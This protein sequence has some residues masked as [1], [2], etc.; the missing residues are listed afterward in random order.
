M[1]TLFRNMLKIQEEWI[2]RPSGKITSQILFARLVLVLI[3]SLLLQKTIYAGLYEDNC[4]ALSGVGQMTTACGDGFASLTYAALELVGWEDSDIENLEAKEEEFEARLKSEKTRFLAN[5]YRELLQYYWQYQNVRSET[6]S[7][8]NG[9]VTGESLFS[10]Y[11]YDRR[12]QLRDKQKQKE[13]LERRKALARELIRFQRAIN[14]I[15]KAEEPLSKRTQEISSNRARLAQGVGTSRT[16]DGSVM[17]LNREEARIIEELNRLKAA[18]FTILNNYPILDLDIWKKRVGNQI[19]SMPSD[20]EITD[21]D[22]NYVISNMLDPA[23]LEIQDNIMKEAKATCEQG[24]G[25]LVGNDFLAADAVYESAIFKEIYCREYDKVKGKTIMKNT[26]LV[27][28]AVVSVAAA[29]LSGGTSTLALGATLV[30]AGATLVDVGIAAHD[31][32]NYYDLKREFF[33]RAKVEG[34]RT[35]TLTSIDEVRSAKTMAIVSSLMAGVGTVGESIGIVRTARSAKGVARGVKAGEKLGVEVGEKVVIATDDVSDIRIFDGREY[36]ITQGGRLSF[37]DEGTE[38]WISKA[39]KTLMGD[40]IEIVEIEG[41]RYVRVSLDDGWGELAAPLERTRK[42]TSAELAKLAREEAE[43]DKRADDL[44]RFVNENDGEAHLAP[45]SGSKDRG[46]IVI[47]RPPTR[48][49][50]VTPDGQNYQIFQDRRIFDIQAEIER[51]GGKMVFDPDIPDSF[52]AYQWQKA[53]PEGDFIVAFRHNSDYLTARHE[54]EHMYHRLQGAD[55]PILRRVKPPVSGS[56]LRQSMDGRGRELV[57]RYWTEQ[58]AGR[59]ELSAA[60]RFKANG[61]RILDGEI[62]LATNETKLALGRILIEPSNP[63]HYTLLLNSG[64]RFVIKKSELA[65]Y[66]HPVAT[67]ATVGTTALATVAIADTINDYV[68]LDA[69]LAFLEDKGIADNF[70]PS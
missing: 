5:N 22:I 15:I 19:F 67:S 17:Q 70:I 45:F 4:H 42:L 14:E 16:V 41:K 20:G 64:V 34:N 68:L 50:K 53:F 56:S 44:L 27:A 62:Y 35:D 29:P 3:F 65:A 55:D 48:Q 61:I 51:N 6:F 25:S 32:S 10:E 24:V 23:L 49:F 63:D 37:F 1:R 60:G 57:S 39:D 12:Y 21:S 40:V 30:G 18:K 38:K 9:G 43:F 33:T 47:D 31:I 7:C 8:D 59:A 58:G 46:V 52:G 69:I 36:T 13:A 26:G 54:L 11:A 28:L 66:L 2:L